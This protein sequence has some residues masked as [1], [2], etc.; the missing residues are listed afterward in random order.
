VTLYKLKKKS[1]KHTIAI[2]IVSLI[3]LFLLSY[4]VGNGFLLENDHII[5][6]A[7]DFQV[8]LENPE[9]GQIFLPGDDIE[10]T[11]TVVGGPISK[12]YI[13]DDR[14]N[15]PI[16]AAITACRFGISVPADDLSAGPH[17]L[18]LQ[19]QCNDGRWSPVVQIG[20]E[21]EGGTAAYKTWC[22]S[23]LPAPLSIIF[24]PAEEIVKNIIIVVGGGQSPDDINGDG[25]QDIFQQSAVVPRYN[26]LGL[27]LTSL[28]VFAI[29]SFIVFVLAYY[30]IRP[31]MKRRQAMKKELYRSPQ[32]QRFVYRMKEIRQQN[33]Q[34]KLRSERA[35]SRRLEKK[36]TEEQ[37]KRLEV[38]E[39]KLKAM[40]KR[41]VKIYL[42]EKR[43]A[44][45]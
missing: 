17:V 25:I 16:S 35:K 27:P 18:C 43:K 23:N 13:W 44:K 6:T 41:P 33:Y 21:K 30:G 40:A 20:I 2:V 15:V 22:E 39:E 9:E 26:P 38:Q 36:L 12:V 5:N 1:K 8:W 42:G 10:I 34:A 14:Y 32:Q 4:Y 28:I 11:G 37:E 7:D 3:L 19:A 29:I 45:K 31:Y 24:R